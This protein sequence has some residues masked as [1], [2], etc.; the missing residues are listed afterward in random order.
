MSSCILEKVNEQN[1]RRL[2][3]LFGGDDGAEGLML[4][5]GISCQFV[6]CGQ[7]VWAWD[8]WAWAIDRWFLDIMFQRSKPQLWL[9]YFGLWSISFH[10]FMFFSHVSAS[11]SG[12]V[13]N[14]GSVST[15]LPA[16]V[17]SLN[18][19]CHAWLCFWKCSQT[20]EKILNLH[21]FIY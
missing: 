17:L 5:S 1:F 4:T 20:Y 18:K 15:S 3:L 10:N 12:R 9:S 16:C 19:S 8:I 2:G 7:P 6:P 21:K 14:S 11:A 13:S